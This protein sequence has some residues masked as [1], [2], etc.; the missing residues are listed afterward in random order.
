MEARCP[1]DVGGTGRA[2]RRDGSVAQREQQRAADGGASG[3]GADLQGGRGLVVED[4]LGGIVQVVELAGAHG[5]H[6]EHGEDRAEQ[7]GDGDQEDQR[8]HANCLRTVDSTREAPQ[9]TMALDRGISTAATS[10]L[11]QPAT[12][13]LTA[14]IL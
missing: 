6:E 2:L 4:A 8:V 7:H 14:T 5:Q 10:G 1:A 11:T 12:A 9:M 3:G 13:A